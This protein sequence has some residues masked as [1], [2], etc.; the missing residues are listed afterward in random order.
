MKKKLLI[1]FL[2]A[3]A[4]QLTFAQTA[5]QT[6]TLSVL[7]VG[8]GTTTLGTSAA[9]VFIDEYTTAGALVRSISLPKVG[10]GSNKILTLDGNTSSVS[11]SEGLL[12]LSQDG[13]KLTL[14]GYDATVGTVTVATSASATNKRVVGVIDGAGTV[15]TA[16]ALDI[17]NGAL[18][19]SAVADGNDLWIS[20]GSANIYYTTI[21]AT[22]ATSIAS[23]TG[24]A[25]R[26]FNGQLYTS[27]IS[28]SDGP[29]VTIGSG[30]PKTAGQTVAGL[31]GLPTTAA[32]GREYFFAD[33]DATIA[34][35]D[36][37]Y[38]ANAATSSGIAKYSLVSGSWVSNGIVTGQ[39]TG[40]TGV[41]SG[42]TVTLY[43]IKF[44]SS[45]NTLFKI[46][47]NTGYNEDISDVL[48]PLTTL[49]TAGTNTV[50]HGIAL[51]P[52]ETTTP[53]SLSSFTGK[54]TIKGVE[55]NWKTASEQNNSH[56][57]IFR[58]T[59]GQSFI[60]QGDVKG[61]G[62]SDRV[63][64]YSFL[65][66]FA[67]AGNNYYKLRQVDLDGKHTEY[68]PI[69]INSGLQETDDGKI[70]VKENSIELTILGSSSKAEIIIQNISGQK[71][72]ET[73]ANLNNEV[74]LINIPF[75][76]AP[77]VYVLSIKKG[78][79]IITKKFIK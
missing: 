69:V 24:R 34:G 22:L 54:L 17:Y 70:N 18:I 16:T 66:Q 30:L 28:G 47:D 14:T 12:S 57:E 32:T 60:M 40:L 48:T 58:S 68:G 44:G 74:N 25:M 61:N 65:D 10:S 62:T 55:L 52:K 11:S 59:D 27:Q 76:Q 5:F 23:R 37:L 67:T 77:G 46:T 2:F 8:D 6:G 72:I 53:V 13:K 35:Y 45:A 71:L 33:V 51:S 1:S 64:T 50:F 63:L 56:Y 79:K 26:I 21:G 73:S 36:V 3:V 15:N 20:G 31:S 9:P 29:V 78:N 4:T 39:Y 49:A 19:S 38:V 7:R 41:V 75:F 42:T 43:G